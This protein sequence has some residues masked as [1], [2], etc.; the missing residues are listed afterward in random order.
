MP[1]T[2]IKGDAHPDW[3]QEAR[4]G[5]PKIRAGIF[6]GRQ[7]HD[8]EHDQEAPSGRSLQPEV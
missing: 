2:E 3:T 8:G 1:Q 7:R 6:G 4:E 5:Y